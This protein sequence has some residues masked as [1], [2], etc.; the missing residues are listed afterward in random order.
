MTVNNVTGNSTSNED[1][2]LPNGGV[3]GPNGDGG[4]GLLVW[5]PTV[6][7]WEPR[8]T[9][10]INAPTNVNLTDGDYLYDD[11]EM[12]KWNGLLGEDFYIIGDSITSPNGGTDGAITYDTD[13]GGL[14]TGVTVTDVGST[15][16]RNFQLS[17]RGINNAMAWF[18]VVI[19]A[20]AISTVT[21][22]N[23]SLP[24][25]VNLVDVNVN[26]GNGTP[27]NSWAYLMWNEYALSS[28]S[29]IDA[30]P[31]TSIA[32]TGTKYQYN[33]PSAPRT[34]SVMLVV[35][36]GNDAGGIE[37]PPTGLGPGGQVFDITEAQFKAAYQALL[38]DGISKGYRV[39]VGLAAY[40]RFE[41]VADDSTWTQATD[42]IKQYQRDVCAILGL[43]EI[44]DFEVSNL[45]DLLHPTQ[46]G[47]NIL[48]REMYPRMSAASCPRV[49]DHAN[50]G[51]VTADQHHPQIHN[52]ASHSDVTITT[53]TDGDVLTLSGGV[54]I[55]QAP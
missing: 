44:W 50:L 3:D 54:W 19:V 30:M 53:P 28:N 46:I 37:V 15:F 47:H 32:R 8:D 9:L 16:T 4:D 45:G 12:G 21:F 34:G 39:I 17:T 51:N 42:L 25:A 6:Q 23:Q 29:H 52:L 1:G 55:N 2:N 49:I 5:N 13:A 48:R 38:Q 18:D 41:T 31:A 33:A 27:T 43:T 14:I 35:L 7:R 10:L 40:N 36:G 11:R 24:F 20:G 26:I 22:T